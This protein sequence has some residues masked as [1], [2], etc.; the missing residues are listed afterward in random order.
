MTDI[1]GDIDR[2]LLY[3]P[4][5]IG[6]QVLSDIAAKGVKEVFVN[7]GAESDALF[8]AAAKLGISTVFACGIVDIGD[9]PSKY[10][11]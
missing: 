7:P 8:E 1:P 5:E 3:V 10:G 6:I 2:A 11:P 9:S 4:P